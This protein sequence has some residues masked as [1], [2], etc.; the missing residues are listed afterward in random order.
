MTDK[1]VLADIR[2]GLL[3][4]TL[5]RPQKR[6]ALSLEMFE[7]LGAAMHRA[8]HPS[9]R[10]VL[11]RGN[12]PVFCAGIDVNALAGQVGGSREDGEAF[13]AGLQD[14]FMILERSGKPSVAAVQGAALGAG[15]QLA[16]ACDLRV[17]AEDATLGLLEIHY[18]IVPDLAGIH[19]MVGL[20]GPAHTLDLVLTGREVRPKKAQRMGF[21]DRVVEAGELDSAAVALVGDIMARSPLAMMAATRLVHSAAA[22][23][24]AE[25]NLR[26]VREAQLDLL[27]SADF[28]EAVTAR[29]A[30]RAPNF[31]G[32]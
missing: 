25:E 2:D 18:G 6:N 32:K 4:I 26:K 28:M 17:V 31:T 29:M 22:G 23:D 3:T 20:C 8:E 10:G 15:L 12:G 5:D 11:V 16:L 9:V 1:L 21:V 19:R 27:A 30:R 24:S 7:Q 14:V 13:I